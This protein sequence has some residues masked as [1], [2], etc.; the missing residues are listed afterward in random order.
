V[1]LYLL[2]ADAAVETILS[3][4]PLQWVVLGTVVGYFIVSAALWRYLSSPASAAAS[5]VLVLALVAGTAWL[6]GGLTQGMAMLRQPTST[7]LAGVTGAAIL[8]GT[9]IVAGWRFVP[10][11]GRLGAGLIA[12]YGLTAVVLGVI[13]RVP[14]ADLFHGHSEWQRLPFWL[15]GVFLAAALLAVTFLVHLIH[16]LVKVRGQRLRAWG[17]ET[18]VVALALAVAAAGFALPAA[19]GLNGG[20]V[21]LPSPPTP[22]PA[23]PGPSGPASPAGPPGPLPQPNDGP[24]PSVP[25]VAQPSGGP[26]VPAPPVAQP[27]AGPAAGAPQPGT[28]GPAPAPAQI[29]PRPPRASAYEGTLYFTRFDPGTCPNVSKVAF[30][31]ITDSEFTPEKPQQV[32]CVPNADGVIFAPD[33]DLLVG[34]GEVIF[35]VKAQSGQFSSVKS[36]GWALHLML[37]PNQQQVWASSI[38]GTPVTIPL[39]PFADG[40]RRALVGDDTSVTTIAWDTAGHA[41]YTASGA[42]GNGSF[43]TIDLDAW[44]TTRRWSNL[45]AAHG[46]AFDPFTRHLILMGSAHLTQIDPGPPVTVVSDFVLDHVDKGN[47]RYNLQFDQGAVDGQGH[48]YAADNDGF[49]VFVDYSTTGRIGDPKNFTSVQFLVEKLDDVAPLVGPGAVKALKTAPKKIEVIQEQGRIRIVLSSDILFDFDKS[50]LEPSAE[51]GLTEAKGII[52]K[53]PGAHVIIEGHT[54]DRGTQEYNLKLSDHRAQ[55]VSDWLKRHG[56]QAGLVETKGY[57][58]IRPRYPNTNEDNRHKNRRVEIIV[59]K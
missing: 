7:V 26:A 20:G 34:G 32:A 52:N 11:W 29:A 14:Y 35:K 59:V 27:S 51:A 12:L 31:Y 45:P 58:K 36:G 24:A 44:K 21:V 48:I 25:Q 57:G 28:P 19:S 6:P 30:T 2:I 3:G 56:I 33:G 23:P 10:L 13:N 4:S 54:D 8:L 37:D 39:N 18:A 38:P 53:Y 42:R 22:V 50:V 49:I 41:F 55:S 9:V 40:T 17:L 46:M 1:L 5:V 15:Q 16:G 47:L 43:G